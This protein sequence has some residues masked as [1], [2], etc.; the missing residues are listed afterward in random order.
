MVRPRAL[1]APQAGV[2]LGRHLAGYTYGGTRPGEGGITLAWDAPRRGTGGGP[3]RAA[4]AH[5]YEPAP[6]WAATSA[7][8]AGPAQTLTLSLPNDLPPGLYVP[9]V[10]VLAGGEEQ[11]SRTARGVGMGA[12]ALAPLRVAAA[13]SATGAEEPLGLYG[14][15]QAPPVAALLGATLTPAE[16]N[17]AQVD[18]LWRCERQAPLHYVLSVRIDRPDGARLAARDLHRLLG[19]Y[20][21]GLWRPGSSSRTASSCPSPRAPHRGCAWRWSSTTAAPS[22]APAASW[23]VTPFGSCLAFGYGKVPEEDPT[24]DTG[25]NT[26]AQG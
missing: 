12:P 21:T 5:L 24:E 19:A 11:P 6:T 17:L 1:P 14:P 20:P 10:R 13:R 26:R 23:W 4:T 18:L 8:L 22:R 15:E 9:V 2:Y 3:L 7:P 16:G 25:K